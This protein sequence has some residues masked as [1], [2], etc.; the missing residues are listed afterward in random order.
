MRPTVGA[1]LIVIAGSIGTLFNIQQPVFGTVAESHLTIERA[2]V[3]IADNDNDLTAR[4]SVEG[5]DIPTDGAEGAFGYGILTQDGNATLVAHTHLGVLDSEDQTFTE[6]PIWHTH[7]VKL[8]DV[9]QCGDNNQGIVD[10]T[11]QSPG[12][13]SIDG[14]NVRFSGIPTGEYK[15]WD[16]ISGKPL[17]MTLGK[18]VSDAVSFKLKPVFD[19]DGLEAI[20]VTDIRSAEEGVNNTD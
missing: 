3:S 6:D 5:V 19:E 11:W 13:V 17:T 10:I 4:L 12:K 18:D 1:L 9:K 14:N 2:D 15:G 8:G 16:S 20:C 7:L